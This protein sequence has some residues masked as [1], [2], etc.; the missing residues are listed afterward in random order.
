MYALFFKDRDRILFFFEYLPC[1]AHRR[2]RNVYQVDEL[3]N[4]FGVVV[5]NE[6]Q[7]YFTS[8]WKSCLPPSPPIPLSAGV[9][10]APW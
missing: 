10:V 8:F 7:D 5:G 4:K 2:W 3:M 6:Q 1:L 9:S